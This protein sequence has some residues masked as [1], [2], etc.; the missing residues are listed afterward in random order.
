MKAGIVGC[1]GSDDQNW[2]AD[3]ENHIVTDCDY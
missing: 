3:L 2:K 1:N